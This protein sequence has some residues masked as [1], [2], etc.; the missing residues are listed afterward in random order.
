MRL[1]HLVLIFIAF[2]GFQC[3]SQDAMPIIEPTTPEMPTP[4]P[5]EKYA[6]LALGD[7]YTI[8]HSVAEED[9]FPVQ[10]SNRLIAQGFDMEETKIV[11]KTGWTTDELQNGIDQATELRDT[12]QLVSLLIGVNNQYRNRPVE[13][14]KPE[15]TELLN[16][17][18]DFAGGRKDR[19]FVVSIPDYAFTPFGSGNPNISEGIDMY[20]AANKEITEAMGIAYY[21]ITPI[22]RLGLQQPELVASDGLHPSREQYRRWVELMLPGVVE[23]LEN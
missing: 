1:R 20:N 17:A 23:L 16:Q 2:S 10:L 13:T 7:S 9:R 12:Y 21:D 11:A 14:Y 19:V 18:I 22:S 5:T 8:G 4:P 15:F 3:T 6:Y